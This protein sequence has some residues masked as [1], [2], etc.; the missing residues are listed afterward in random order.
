MHV[1]KNIKSAVNRIIKQF[2]SIIIRKS[3]VAVF[4]SQVAIT[5]M[6]GK[7]PKVK[8]AIIPNGIDLSSFY[9]KR[10]RASIMKKYNIPHYVPIV[11][12]IG[13]VDPEKSIDILIKAFAKAAKTTPAHLLIVGDGSSRSTLEKLAT[14]LKISHLVHFTGRV[15]GSDLVDLYRACTLYTT[16]SLSEN[17]S[18]AIIEALSCGKPII[19]PKYN[20][21]TELVIDGKNGLVFSPRNVNQMANC[22]TRILKNQAL[23]QKLS[24]GATRSSKAYD[25]KTCARNYEKV[26]K[27][28]IQSRTLSS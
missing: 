27:E 23:C 26:Y 16:A 21:M 2:L 6:L 18:I 25:I 15:I 5:R 12:F 7:H 10:P 17:H 14:R 28:A 1:P 24:V 9:P 19:A 3:D 11:G 22:I 13:R 4:L 8:T 20:P